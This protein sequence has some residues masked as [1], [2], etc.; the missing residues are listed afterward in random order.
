MKH[1]V[2]VEVRT[3]SLLWIEADPN[4]FGR[5]FAEMNSEEQVLVLAAMVEH[6]RPHRIQWDYI[7][8]ELERPENSEILN[9]LRGCLFPNE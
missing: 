6:M 4:E 5:V 1:M 7:S 3:N 2:G 8:I 9:E